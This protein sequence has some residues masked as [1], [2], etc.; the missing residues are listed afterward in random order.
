MKF[1]HSDRQMHELSLPCPSV[2]KRLV[3]GAAGGRV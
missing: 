1:K 2:E 3:E